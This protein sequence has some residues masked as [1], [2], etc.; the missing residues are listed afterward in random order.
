MGSGHSRL[1][2]DS[3]GHIQDNFANHLELAAE[4]VHE[5]PDQVLHAQRSRHVLTDLHEDNPGLRARALVEHP[6]GVRAQMPVG[7]EV[8]FALH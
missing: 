6:L 1:Q 3:H 7:E 4:Q 2:R 5:H 8:Q